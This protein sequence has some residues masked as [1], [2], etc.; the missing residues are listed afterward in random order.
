MGQRAIFSKEPDQ[1][2][3]LLALLTVQ[4]VSQLLSYAEIAWKQ[5]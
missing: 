1:S 2:Q 3:T 4:S 5:P